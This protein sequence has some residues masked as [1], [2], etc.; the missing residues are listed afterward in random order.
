[1][2]VTIGNWE[3]EEEAEGWE[4]ADKDELY[5]AGIE[6]AWKSIILIT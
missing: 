4:E 3:E 6:I 1:M 2:S 5:V